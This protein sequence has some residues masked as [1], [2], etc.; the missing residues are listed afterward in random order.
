MTAL[1]MNATH[2]V[3]LIAA[4]P[5]ARESYAFLIGRQRDLE[6][7]G[8]ARTVKEAAQQMEV[9]APDAILMSQPAHMDMRPSDFQQLRSTN[10]QLPIVVVT[11]SASVTRSNPVLK[12]E[13]T[14]YLTREQV[15]FDLLPLLRQTLYPNAAQSMGSDVQ[16]S[17]SSFSPLPL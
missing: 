8:Q 7:T 5:V 15:P 10:E 2:S 13:A 6:I 9:V 14:A 3:Y 11:P 12:K 1:G 4:H 17:P 16:S